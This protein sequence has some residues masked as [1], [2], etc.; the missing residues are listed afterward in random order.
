V[1]EWTVS[2]VGGGGFNV[3][4]VLTNSKGEIRIVRGDTRTESGV[5]MARMCVGEQWRAKE[6]DGVSQG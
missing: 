4:I 2:E 3:R 6:D 1:S 5:K